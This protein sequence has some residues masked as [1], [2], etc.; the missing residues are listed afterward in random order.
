MTSCGIGSIHTKCYD[1]YEGKVP[2]TGHRKA[3][4]LARPLVEL[5]VGVT[6]FLL[7]VISVR[8]RT[9]VDRWE[10]LADMFA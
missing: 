3:I 6:T 2:W 1:S 10:Y 5:K 8:C 9:A 7:S 4:I